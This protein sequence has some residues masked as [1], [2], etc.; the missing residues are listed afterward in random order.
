MNRSPI[1]RGQTR[2]LASCCVYVDLIDGGFPD[3]RAKTVD[4]GAFADLEGG[5]LTFVMRSVYLRVFARA[6]RTDMRIWQRAFARL[7]QPRF[8]VGSQTQ[9]VGGVSIGFFLPQAKSWVKAA[10]R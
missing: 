6:T 1:W 10:L 9:L 3:N 5:Y 4:G 7:G 8:V 2:C